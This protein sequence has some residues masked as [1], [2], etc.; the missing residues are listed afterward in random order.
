MKDTYV[1]VSKS[2]SRKLDIIDIPYAEYL[3][4]ITVSQLGEARQAFEEN[5]QVLKKN[6]T[7][8]GYT[9]VTEEIVTKYNRNMKIKPTGDNVFK[10]AA[11]ISN[12]V[13]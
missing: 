9:E 3:I 2:P 8:G 1:E 4:R 5:L 13:G 11:L 10:L 12:T 6:A 7:G